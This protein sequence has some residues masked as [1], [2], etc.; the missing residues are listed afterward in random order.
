MKRVFK[1]IALAVFVS[2][3]LARAQ[4][5]EDAQTSPR[6]EEILRLREEAESLKARLEELE[7]RLRSLESEAE[8]APKAEGV[9]E[10]RELE[11]EI[12]AALE[13]SGEPP[14]S[15]PEPSERG[16]GRAIRAISRAFNPAI[17]VNGLF[18]GGYLSRRDAWERATGFPFDNGLNLQEVEGRFTA[19]VD[20]FLTADLTLT[21]D[22]EG[23]SDVEEAYVK[24]MQSPWGRIPSGLG[25]R[26]GRFL[27]PF[28]RHNLWHTHQWP[29]IDQ[30]LANHLLFGEEG[31]GELGAEAS[32][33]LPATW[34]SEIALAALAGD[35]KNLFGE[36]GGRGSGAYLAH[37]KN[38]FDLGE[39]TTLEVGQSYLTGKSSDAGD[40]WTHVAGFDLTLKWRPLERAVYRSLVWQTEA[41]YLGRDREAAPDYHLGGIYSYIAYQFA[42][43]WWLQFRYDNFASL[44]PAGAER[45]RWTTMLALAPSEF[46]AVRLQYAYATAEGERDMQEILLQL[47][48]TI[49]S[50]PAHNY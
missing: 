6:E 47:N 48:Y 49:G 9:E 46:S 29:F 24:L 31:I 25:L 27:V 44:R 2:L 3:P 10:G 8:P 1:T 5:N 19:D 12:E 38:F 15:G 11:R 33:L 50:H 42:R 17:S 40:P 26:A 43:L 37:L 4:A 18:A 45:H 36:K 39:S 34:Y 22:Q 28:G 30:P 23:D 21:F 41:I 20:P 14:A 35:N 7:R 13:R 32:Y 16:S